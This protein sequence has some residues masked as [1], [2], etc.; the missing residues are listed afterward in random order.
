MEE[1]NEIILVVNGTDRASVEM[2]NCI[3][4]H[5]HEKETSNGNITSASDVCMVYG[6]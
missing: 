3:A 2:Q 6:I 5:A 1:G 4:F